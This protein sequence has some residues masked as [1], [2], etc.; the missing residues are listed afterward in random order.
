METVIVRYAEVALKG[1]NR[2][3][4]VEQLAQNV[5]RSLRLPRRA[6]SRESGQLV[7][8]AGEQTDID[9]LAGV[10]GVAWYARASTCSNDPESIKSASAEMARRLLQP[11]QS[12]AVRAKRA[13]KQLGYT[14]PELEAAVGRAV[15]QATQARVDLDR[16]DHTIHIYCDQTQAY[17][18]GERRQGPGGLPV[19]VSGRALCLLSGGFDSIAAA[20]LLA[21][22]GA[23]VDFLH[24]YAYPT[25]D[26]VRETKVFQI[27]QKLRRFTFSEKLYIAS[28]MPFQ[29]ATLSLARGEASHELVVFRRFMARVGELLAQR[30]GYQALIFGD[31]LGQVASQTMTNLAALDAAVGL[32]VLRPVIGF[33][34]V[35]VM[36]LVQSIGLYDLAAA[37]YKDCC[38]LIAAHPATRASLATVQ[39]IEDEI[40]A[41]T[42]AQQAA[43][44]VEAVKLTVREA[45]L[46]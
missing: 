28:Y 25:L 29:M 1:K 10:F 15:Q 3:R 27:A 17:I 31:S 35:E 39:R 34:K 19:G 26:D 9:A 13:D 14:S 30:H 24:F 36:N 42:L 46:P 18:Y 32:P 7:F 33:D 2:K 20:Y 41:R 43:E 21:K 38:S 5:C 6:V 22:R 4:F 40:D 8:R 44:Q 12:F 45:S 23:R 37:P 11:G 16:P